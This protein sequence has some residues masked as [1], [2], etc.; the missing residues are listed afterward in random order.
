MEDDDRTTTGES[1]V[2]S[3]YTIK[4]VTLDS[5]GYPDEDDDSSGLEDDQDMEIKLP[6]GGLAGILALQDYS[7]EDG[8]SSFNPTKLDLVEEMAHKD[9]TG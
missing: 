3:R 1:L 8:G 4:G 6:E 2:D 9:L 7:R 5:F